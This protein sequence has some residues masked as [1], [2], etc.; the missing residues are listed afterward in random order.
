MPISNIPDLDEPVF[1]E[2]WQAQ[3]FALTIALHRGGAFTWSEWAAAL[4]D[5]LRTADGEDHHAAWLNALERLLIDKR[6]ADA[7]SLAALK[8]AWSDAYRRTPH[9]SA[10]ALET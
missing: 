10:V 3:V 6:L 4:G 7:A 8:V 5:R 9:G 2:P 1:A